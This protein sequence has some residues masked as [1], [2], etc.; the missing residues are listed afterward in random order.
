M[1][2]HFCGKDREA[3]STMIVGFYCIPCHRIVI[4]ESRDAIHEIKARKKK[5]SN[6]PL[7]PTGKTGG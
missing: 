1:I 3:A 2:C 7:Q 6:Q 4:E 5:A